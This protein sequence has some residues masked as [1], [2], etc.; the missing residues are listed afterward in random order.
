M[1]TAFPKMRLPVIA[2]YTREFWFVDLVNEAVHEVNFDHPRD[3]LGIFVM[4]RYA[5]PLLTGL[6]RR[7]PTVAR[8]PVVV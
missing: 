6:H 2:T 5:C 4:T 8:G 3:L 1:L 7:S